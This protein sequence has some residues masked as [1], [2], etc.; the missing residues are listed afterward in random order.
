MWHTL[1]SPCRF[2]FTSNVSSSQSTRIS[3]TA[4]RL[5]E[6]SPFI[7]S[8]SRV[9]LKIAE[10][11]QVSALLSSIFTEEDETRAAPAVAAAAIGSLDGAH[12]EFLR[13]LAEHERWPREDVERLAAEL[14][15]M[16]DGALEATERQFTALLQEAAQGLAIRL[17]SGLEVPVP[18]FPMGGTLIRGVR[19]SMR[20]DLEKTLARAERYRR[21]RGSGRA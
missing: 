10:T 20:A 4:S 13:R 3:V 15:L 5:P 1:P 19:E 16:P 6:V 17:R 11:R 14:S 8:V 12:S 7:Q 21:E 18:A 2:T 9:R